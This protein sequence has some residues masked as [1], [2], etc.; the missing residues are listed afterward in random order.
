MRRELTTLGLLMALIVVSSYAQGCLNHLGN[1]IDWWVVLKVPPKIGSS[2]FGYYDSTFKSGT[3]Q[4]V[5][6]FVDDGATALTMTMHQI[7]ILSM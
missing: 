3:F 6:N 2:G 7:N 4:Y 1:P 5:P